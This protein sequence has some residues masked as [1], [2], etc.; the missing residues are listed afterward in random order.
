MARTDALELAG[1]VAGD[2]GWGVVDGPGPTAMA[3]PG[4]GLPQPSGALAGQLDLDRDPLGQWVDVLAVQPRPGLQVGVVG[5][6]DG[7]V[8]DVALAGFAAQLTL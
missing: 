8:G 6:L 5:E 2:L 4:P 1:Q 7:A 3:G